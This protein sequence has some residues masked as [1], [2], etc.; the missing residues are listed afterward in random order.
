MEK[1]IG[2]RDKGD[3]QTYAIIGAAIEVHNN[4][5]CGFLEAV[6][7]S[8]LEIELSKRNV[9]FQ[10]QVNVPIFY[11]GTKLE[12]AYR[13]DLVCF[14]NILIELKA[15]KTITDIEIAQII[16]YLKAT[17]MHRGLLINFGNNRLT[18][19]RFVNGKLVSESSEI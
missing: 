13:A 3:P 14:E 5:G 12:C 16:N 19:K 9:P 10:S 8:A 7:Q 17:G 6:Y 4:L 1:M 11:K 15:I 18:C 2:N